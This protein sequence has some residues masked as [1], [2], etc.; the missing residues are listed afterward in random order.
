M[1]NDQVIIMIST[2]TGQGLTVDTHVMSEEAKQRARLYEGTP[3]AA[4]A[5][6]AVEPAQHLAEVD[7]TPPAPAPQ[8]AAAK[9]KPWETIIGTPKGLNFQPPPELHAKMEWVSKNVPGGMSRLAILRE[10]A[11][12]LCDAMIAK[13]YREEE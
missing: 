1:A 9:A 12:M 2:P 8:A 11:M 6:Q 4:G 3:E 13:H 10:G 7:K 5:E